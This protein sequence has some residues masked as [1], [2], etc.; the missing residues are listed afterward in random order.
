MLNSAVIKAA[1]AN[2]RAGTGRK[3]FERYRGPAPLLR[4]WRFFRRGTP[5][6]GDQVAVRLKGGCLAL[7]FG[8]CLRVL[9]TV[10]AG[11]AS[12]CF[13]K[14]AA[15]VKNAAAPRP[16]PARVPRQTP[17]NPLKKAFIA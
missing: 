5:A 10:C 7:S 13:G 8:S 6:I 1:E 4:R 17:P 9:A 14:T 2:V 16:A 15:A 11:A 12:A 3:A